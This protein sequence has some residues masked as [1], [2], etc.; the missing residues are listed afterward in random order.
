MIVE[1]AINLPIQ[2]TFDYLWPSS[3]KNMPINGMLI[4]VPFG[5]HKKG[6]I[7]VDVKHLSK[8]SNLKKVEQIV[9]ELPIFNREIL[10]LTKWTSSY[11]FCA[12]GEALNAAIPG[13]L[14]LRLLTTYEKQ[15][16]LIPNLNKLSKST[17]ELIFSL[18][19]WTHQDWLSSKANSSDHNLLNELIAKKYILIKHTLLGQKNKQ[20]VE[21]WVRLVNKVFTKDKIIRKK[22]KRQQ[23]IEILK[24]NPQ[25][26]WSDIQSRVKS[27]SQALKKLKD[28]G[29]IEFYEKRIFRRFLDGELPK[30]QQ[31]QVLN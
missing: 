2:K 7:V 28:D 18:T 10:D 8:F 27:P 5:I 20:K 22:T 17:Y 25:I 31:F 15:S 9:N 6:G 19:S 11:Y 26:C 13:G 4:L 29:Y 3:F 21:R 24:E 23:I 16:N 1:V 14:A 30:I 12:W